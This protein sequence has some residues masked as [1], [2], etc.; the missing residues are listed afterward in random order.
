M[1]SEIYP[2]SPTTSN[3]NPEDSNLING[4]LTDYDDGSGHPA[5]GIIIVH[6]MALH[7]NPLWKDECERGQRAERFDHFWMKTDRCTFITGSGCLGK[8]NLLVVGGE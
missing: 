5:E 6:T 2:T 4:T 8:K 1:Q 3:L 7:P